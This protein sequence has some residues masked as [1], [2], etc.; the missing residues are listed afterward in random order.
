[1]LANDVIDFFMEELAHPNACAKNIR[2]TIKQLASI[3]P[4][5]TFGRRMLNDQ[6]IDVLF[7]LYSHDLSDTG[8][9]GLALK[10]KLNR[11]AHLRFMPPRQ[12]DNIL[13]IRK[14]LRAAGY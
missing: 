5:A 14:G 3:S 13:P 8:E 2:Q 12:A 7:D 10:S 1:M 4:G 11:Y 9:L 6:L